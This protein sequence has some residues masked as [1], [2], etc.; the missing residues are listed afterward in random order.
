MRMARQGIYVEIFIRGT[1]DDL[2]EK[3]Q[4]PQ[5]HQRWDLRF[6]EIDYLPQPDPSQP[7]QFRYTTRLGF[8]LRIS[9]AGETLGTRDDPDTGATSALKFWSDDPKSL[10]RKGSGYWKYIPQ[11]GGVRFLT[12]YDYET[13]FGTIGRLFDRIVFRP[14]IGWATAWSFDRLRLWIEKQIDPSLS[15]QSSIIHAI[16]R[17]V[18]AFI[19]LYHGLIPK[20]LFLSK[21]ELTLV[22]NAGLQPDA[23]LTLV[24]IIG[25]AEIALGLL[26]L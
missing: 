22:T 20:L 9:G 14:L 21:D 13:R 16:A 15:M 7:Q 10:I 5:L 25:V 6:S 2:W 3:T 24:R 12:W 26:S 19:W 11:D 8:G 18:I 17:I 1:L 23:A 4:T